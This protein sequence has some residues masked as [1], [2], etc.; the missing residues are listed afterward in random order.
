VRT[1]LRRAQERLSY[2]NVTATAA[3]FI[4]LGGTSYAVLSIDSGDV[5]DNSLRSRDVRDDTLRSRDVRDR[6]LRGRDLRRSSLGGDVVKESA[7]APVPH[8]LESDR[9]GGVPAQDFRLRC[10]GD[11]IAKAGICIELAAR[12]PTGFFGALS[13]CSERGRGLV[14]MPQL[15]RFARSS[16]PLPQP[17]WTGSV[18]RNTAN[19]ALPTEQLEAVLLSGGGAPSYERVYLAVQH[20]FRCAALPTN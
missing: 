5:R 2:A 10:P 4:A 12:A 11:T 19:G 6:S 14:T 15:D 13:V 16:G 3:V 9:L 20:A 1:F 7:L 17:E 18:Y 8:A